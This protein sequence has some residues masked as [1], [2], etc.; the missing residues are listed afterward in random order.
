MSE[1]AIVV[2]M[3][4][5]RVIGRGNE[6]PWK[7]IKDDLPNFKRLTSGKTV[8]MGFNTFQ[9]IGK[10]LPNRNNIVIS[11]EPLNIDGVAVCTSIA[12]ALDKARSYKTDVYIIG[13]ASVYEQL[14][15]K[16]NTMYLS[17]IKKDYDGDKYFPAFD[18]GQWKRVAEKDFAEFTFVTFKR[19]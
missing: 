2:G 7:Q 14:L 12:E 19:K 5:N 10:P 9:S 15:P 13:G 8:I 18:E 17:F 11:Q 16:V 4:K 3:T 1:L 6:L